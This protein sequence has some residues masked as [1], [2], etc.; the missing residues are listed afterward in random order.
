MLLVL[1]VS[2]QVSSSMPV[3]KPEPGSTIPSQKTER[4]D[5]YYD[6]DFSTAVLHVSRTTGFPSITLHRFWTNDTGFFVCFEYIRDFSAFNNGRV[7]ILPYD[8][9]Q[10]GLFVVF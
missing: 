4:G 9:K 7:A 2:G 5:F 10:N 1:R 6:F 8:K 3:R